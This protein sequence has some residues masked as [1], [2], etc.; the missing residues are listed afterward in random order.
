MHILV[1]NVVQRTSRSR[2]S[3]AHITIHD[4]V[5]RTSSS[6]HPNNL[7]LFQ[8]LTCL[9]GCCA[10]GAMQ[11]PQLTQVRAA[12]HLCRCVAART[13]RSARGRSIRQRQR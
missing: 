5:P 4:P 3:D 9:R 8:T 11:A 10:T 1:Q 13:G 6:Q 7:H 2:T 12:A